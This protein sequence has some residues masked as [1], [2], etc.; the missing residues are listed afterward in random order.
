M[1]DKNCGSDGLG[2]VGST[3]AFLELDSSNEPVGETCFLEREGAFGLR[4]DFCEGGGEG[5]LKI[6]RGG[7]FSTFL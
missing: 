2:D 7:L 4:V 3:S 1:R 5:D 6:G